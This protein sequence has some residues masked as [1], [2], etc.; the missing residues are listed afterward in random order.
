MAANLA[1][2]AALW[3]GWL[4]VLIALA[5]C[6]HLAL[7]RPLPTQVAAAEQPAD[8][9]PATWT[10][11]PGMPAATPFTLH[12]LPSP[13]PTEPRPA[14][15]TVTPYVPPPTAT[16]RPTATPEPTG[17]PELRSLNDYE[18]DEVVPLEAF[19]RPPGDNGWGIHWIPTVKQE[20]AVV[21]RFVA[22]LVRMN[23]K[24]L[25]FLNDGTQIGDND[26]LVER[27]V[28]HNIMPVMRIYRATVTVHDG[29]LGA[30]VRHYRAKGVIYF[31]LYNE[32]NVN[33]ENMQGFANPIHYARIWAEA[34]REVVENGGLPGLGALSPGGAYDHNTFLDRTLRA[35][36]ANGDD[37]LLN[38]TWLSVHNYHGTRPA[39][40]PGGFLLFRQY[41]EIIRAHLHR[42][43]PMIGTEGGSYSDNPE[44]VKYHLAH[45]YGYMAD[46]EPYFFAFSYWVLANLEGGSWDPEWEWQTLFRAGYVH[47]VV[48][49]FFY[50]RSR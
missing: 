34:A 48:T 8:Y 7:A 5:G 47:P 32:P 4:L 44:E 16:P 12:S 26:Y 17:T 14:I 3:A 28:A 43:L 41:D 15:P 13:V 37:V 35:L 22:E 27:L 42:S 39:D 50:R 46:A 18:L 33:M 45:Q 23:I 38:R 24:W 19:P 1:R 40:D 2:R 6:Q 9:I 36:R 49:D 10:P 31:Q 21:D 30:A 29:D 25:T 20:P 11:Q